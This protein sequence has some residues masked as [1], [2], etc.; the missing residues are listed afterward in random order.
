[1]FKL[2]VS[3]MVRKRFAI[4]NMGDSSEHKGMLFSSTQRY[5][6][7]AVLRQGL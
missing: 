1:M 3:M 2:N 4:Q 5:G 7:N 6:V